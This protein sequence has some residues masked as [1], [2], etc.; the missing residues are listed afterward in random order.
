MTE[1][2]CNDTG[3][4]RGRGKSKSKEKRNFCNKEAHL[5]AEYSLAVL[6]TQRAFPYFG[7]VLCNF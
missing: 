4:S 5:W 3:S 7:G 1:V 2:I 6:W